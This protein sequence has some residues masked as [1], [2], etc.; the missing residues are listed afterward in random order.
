MVALTIGS[1]DAGCL[2]AGVWGYSLTALKLNTACHW[3]FCFPTP[4]NC[5]RSVSPIWLH[6]GCP[7]ENR[8]CTK[9]CNLDRYKEA[10]GEQRWRTTRVIPRPHLCC[11][12]SR[13]NR[14]VLAGHN[15]TSLP[16][17]SRNR[18]RP[19]RVARQDTRRK[20]DSAEIS[21]LG[22]HFFFYISMD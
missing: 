20:A 16:S 10:R 21:T 19:G 11:G 1:G 14:A 12:Q 9:R 8:W 4:S 7:R 15:L 6:L 3:Y 5:L 13:Q 22:Q 2:F 17:L 18:L